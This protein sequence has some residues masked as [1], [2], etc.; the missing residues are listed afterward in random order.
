MNFDINKLS[1]LKNKKSKDIKNNL[2]QEDINFIS[3]IFYSIL[4]SEDYDEKIKYLA[5][6]YELIISDIKLIINLYV[7]NIADKEEKK[8]YKDKITI[9]KKENAKQGFIDFSFVIVSTAII[10]V[11]GVTLA[12]ILLTK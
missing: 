7:S 4:N 2:T 12:A 8:K 9:K 6:I 10:C 1:N 11:V 5:G 3:N